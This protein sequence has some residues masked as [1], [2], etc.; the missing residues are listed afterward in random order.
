MPRQKALKC[1]SRSNV[2]I[3]ARIDLG[4]HENESNSLTLRILANDNIYDCDA[5]EILPNGVTELYD[6]YVYG[7]EDRDI[8]EYT[9]ISSEFIERTLGF[10][11]LGSKWV[12]FLNVPG[13]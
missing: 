4:K 5:E 1:R 13:K 11:D 10:L 6:D 3:A 7:D 12:S 8:N 2:N 9:V